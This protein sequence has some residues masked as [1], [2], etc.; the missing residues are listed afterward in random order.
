MTQVLWTFTSVVFSTHAKT[1]VK[2]TL[3]TDARQ[4]KLVSIIDFFTD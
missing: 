4:V 2:L 1:L 3:T